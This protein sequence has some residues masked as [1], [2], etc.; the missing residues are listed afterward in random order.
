MEKEERKK[1]LNDTARLMKDVTDNAEYHPEDRFVVENNESIEDSLEKLYPGKSYFLRFIIFL[2]DLE[3]NQRSWASYYLDQFASKENEFVRSLFQCYCYFLSMERVSSKE[4]LKRSDFWANN[5]L[6]YTKDALTPEE[7]GFARKY[8]HPLCFAV[9]HGIFPKMRAY[10][11]KLKTP[12][13][14]R[15]TW[16]NSRKIAF[17]CINLSA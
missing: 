3:S 11:A 15:E 16:E 17:C 5:A 8:L 14:K 10:V 1:L 7:V 4:T 12:E 13:E 2:E 6:R 9:N